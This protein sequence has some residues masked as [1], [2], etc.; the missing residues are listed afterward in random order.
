MTT[1]N[2]KVAAMGLIGQI[3]D[4]AWRT[5]VAVVAITVFFGLLGAVVHGIIWAGVG[6]LYA[7]FF[8]A[9]WWDTRHHERVKKQI[10]DDRARERGEK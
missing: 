9:C 4:G 1:S 10:E 5:V 7:A 3:W 2:R 8:L 6:G